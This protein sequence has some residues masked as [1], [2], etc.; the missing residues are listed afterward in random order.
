MS[1]PTRTD[2]YKF[3]RNRNGA[4]NNNV[5]STEN[6]TEAEFNTL[7][8]PKPKLA[9]KINNAECI[10]CVYRLMKNV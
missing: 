9:P 1:R 7:F 6:E 2:F 10:M 8:W 5:V 4:E 3:G